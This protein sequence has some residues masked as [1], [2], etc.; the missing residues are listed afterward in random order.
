MKLSAPDWCFFDGSVP[1]DEYYQALHSFGYSAVEMIP[2]ERRSAAR[3]AGLL[4][5]NDGV[6]GFSQGLC[7]R[8]NH[9]I[10]IP[11]IC[12]DLRS[13]E[14]DHIP[15]AIVFSGD[16]N[17][18]ETG[19]GAC[20]DA[21]R[22]ILHDIASLNVVLTFEMFST[23]NHPSYEAVSSE[24]GFKLARDLHSPQFKV[25]YDA[26]HMR[27][28]GEDV[29]RDVDENADL[30]A[31]IHI[32]EPPERSLPLG[33]S[34]VDWKRLVR[35]ARDAGYT[36]HFGMEF[37]PAGDRLAAAREAAQTFLDF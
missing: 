11:R 17:A 31:H 9:D 22:K 35:T 24:Y 6:A 25:L 28:M 3:K 23:Q 13:L 19:L 15:Q 12:Q 26:Y 1:A 37:Q 14:N 36:G 33:H 21:F 30:I 4:V 34:E 16:G 8:E 20:E 5:L 29:Q 18:A 7:N 32:A 27:Q 2:P 10:L